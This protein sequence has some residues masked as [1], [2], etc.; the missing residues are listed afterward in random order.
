[1]EGATDVNANALRAARRIHDGADVREEGEGGTDA[2]L[3][4]PVSQAC[5]RQRGKERQVGQ[6]GVANLQ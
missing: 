2:C 4:A 5:S 6:Q 1:M 3:K